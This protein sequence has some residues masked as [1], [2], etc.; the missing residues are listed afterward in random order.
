MTHIPII[1]KLPYCDPLHIFENFSDPHRLFL[2]SS[3]LDSDHRFS[4][5]A[6]APQPL[7]T[8]K[9]NKVWYRGRPSSSHPISL[10]RQLQNGWKAEPHPE[11]PFQGGWMGYFS[12]ES[13]QWFDPVASNLPYDDLKQ[14]DIE[15]LK[16]GVFVWDQVERTLVA[17]ASYPEARYDRISY[18]Q[19]YELASHA[20]KRRTKNFLH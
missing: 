4:I 6:H 9:Q 11:I 12:F 19:T 10:L 13:D 18:G 20:K 2:Y 1:K 3:R 16:L 8:T 5:L 17:V 7:L 14:A 15:I